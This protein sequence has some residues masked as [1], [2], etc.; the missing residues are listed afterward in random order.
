MNPVIAKIMQNAMFATGQTE[1][2]LYN[3]VEIEAL[4][5]I[6]ESEN[7]FTPA[8]MRT[9]KSVAVADNSIF[10]VKAGDLVGAP[11]RGDTIEYHG[12]KYYV[13]GY[14]V[15]DT[16]S[17]SYVVKATRNERGYLNK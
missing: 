17:D 8:F 12:Q 3:G 6:G 7:Q 2:I 14:D 4:V 10:T 9:N 15:F 16:L 13:G 5:E 1:T 11:K